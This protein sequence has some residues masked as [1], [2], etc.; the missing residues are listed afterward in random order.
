MSHD[1]SYYLIEVVTKAGLTVCR[2]YLY[3]KTGGVKSDITIW[4][5]GCIIFK[6]YDIIDGVFS[7]GMQMFNIIQQLQA[8]LK[9]WS[10]PETRHR[11]HAWCE[12]WF[13]T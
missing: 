9:N 6:N 4:N 13:N 3:I 12:V 1:T 2:E 7:S 11:H 5:G 8:T 10:H